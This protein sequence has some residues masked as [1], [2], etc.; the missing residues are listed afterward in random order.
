MISDSEGWVTRRRGL[1]SGSIAVPDPEFVGDGDLQAVQRALYTHRG[2]LASLPGSFSQGRTFGLM[3]CGTADAISRLEH[4]GL[5]ARILLHVKRLDADAV[6]SCLATNGYR[7]DPAY[8]LLLGAAVHVRSRTRALT[9]RSLPNA[10]RVELLTP[11][12]DPALIR[13][14]QRLEV[15]CGL[16]PVPGWVLRGTDGLT[17]TLVLLDG[18]RQVQGGMSTLRIVHGDE[19]LAMGFGLC[20]AEACA[21]R[22]LAQWLNA[23]ALT[24]AIDGGAS[25]A[26]EIVA[27]AGDASRRVNEACGLELSSVEC[28]L[29]AERI[30]SV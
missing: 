4:A 6:S 3:E 16:T 13:E 24:Q 21:G 7:C 29:F 15:R 14:L 27:P 20:I 5:P 9:I 30:S 26:M 2:A 25:R 17:R 8:D 12:S 11:S 18:E 1:P 22:G 23:A 28:F 19:S 10:W